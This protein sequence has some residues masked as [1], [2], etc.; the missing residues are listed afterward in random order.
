M[1]ETET[2]RVVQVYRVRYQQCDECECITIVER[3]DDRG[4]PDET[5]WEEFPR[6]MVCGGS[7]LHWDADEITTRDR[8]FSLGRRRGRLEAVHELDQARKARI[9]HDAQD[10][11]NYFY[12]NPMAWGYV[13]A[14]NPDL[15][16]R[17][18]EVMP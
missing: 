6:C 2:E 4:V 14:T 11:I 8:E 5:E 18:R 15:V 17:L 9:I 12:E 3:D 10:A 13:K 1:A 16:R 7:M